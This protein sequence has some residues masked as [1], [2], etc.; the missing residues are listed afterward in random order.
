MTEETNKSPDVIEAEDHMVSHGFSAAEAENL[1]KKFGTSSIL[2]D[3]AAKA[4][5]HPHFGKPARAGEA[6]ED[7]E[8]VP[9]EEYEALAESHSELIEALEAMRTQLKSLR[10]KVETLKSQLEEAQKEK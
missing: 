2:A 8:T 7:D 4:P 1:V 6:A 3:K 10:E 5:L 9:K